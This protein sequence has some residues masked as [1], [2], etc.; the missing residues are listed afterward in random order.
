M[1]AG[2][3]KQGAVKRDAVRTGDM[4]R[5]MRGRTSTYVLVNSATEGFALYQHLRS[6][7]L[8]V[9]I[10]PAPREA[11]SCCG[12]S[13]LIGEQGH[14]VTPDLVEQVRV[15]AD[16]SEIGY[17]RIVEVNQYIDPNRHKFC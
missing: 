12:T 3:A 17:D 6:S 4:E 9:R 13:I 11:S 7:G 14:D 2:H 10:A 5:E 15:A 1:V 16:A 8:P